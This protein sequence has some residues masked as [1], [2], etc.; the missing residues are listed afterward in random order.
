[1]LPHPREKSKRHSS[2]HKKRGSQEKGNGDGQGSISED[3]Q[4]E[5][6]VFTEDN[7]S[8]KVAE[9]YFCFIKLFDL[10]LKVPFSTC[11]SPWWLEECKINDYKNEFL[12]R[13]DFSW[14]NSSTVYMYLWTFKRIYL[15]II[16]YKI[17]VY[18]HF[19]KQ[20][21]LIT[22]T[23][24]LYSPW[25]STYKNFHLKWAAPQVSFPDSQGYSTLITHYLK[26]SL[27]RPHWQTFMNTLQHV[28][29]ML[30]TCITI[31]HT[32]INFMS[33]FGF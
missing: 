3:D 12:S 14:V 22:V 27:A 9:V 13:Q 1:M 11:S 23:D 21:T 2:K 33:S 17:L 20:T 24:T 25:M 5:R 7:T 15:C 16:S 30:K 19:W 31:L 6:S 10:N 8:P 18:S 26:L 29:A 28:E 32:Y 4:L